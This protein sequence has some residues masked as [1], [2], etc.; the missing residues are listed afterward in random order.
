MEN[1]YNWNVEVAPY[2]NVNTTIKLL[3]FIFGLV[4]VAPYWNVN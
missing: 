2:W 3:L 4:E 1:M